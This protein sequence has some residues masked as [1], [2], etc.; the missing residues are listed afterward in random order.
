MGFRYHY[1]I[2]MR[3]FQPRL[4]SFDILIEA[5]SITRKDAQTAS[6]DYREVLDRFLS[7]KFAPSAQVE[8]FAFAHR[9]VLRRC[10]KVKLSVPHIVPKA[11]FTR[12]S[13]TSRPKDASRSVG[14]EH[15]VENPMRK[16]RVF[17]LGY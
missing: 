9:E 12:R 15:L 14:A 10:R 3:T 1:I 4:L 16:H 7:V 17:W 2:K 6:R 8:R 5:M 11:H 13:R